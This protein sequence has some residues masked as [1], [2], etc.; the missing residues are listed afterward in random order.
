MRSDCFRSV[1][2]I[3]LDFMW[4]TKV[5]SLT[6]K[7]PEQMSSFKNI[8]VITL[9][10][11]FANAVMSQDVIF[12][13]NIT[14][15]RNKLPDRDDTLRLRPLSSLRY[16]EKDTQW[17]IRIP[18]NTD[19]SFTHVATEIEDSTLYEYDYGWLPN[20]YLIKN[21]EYKL[22]VEV[23]R[24]KETYQLETSSVEEENKYL[25]YYHWGRLPY[26]KMNQSP[27]EFKE[28]MD[29]VLQFEQEQLGTFEVNKGFMDLMSDRLK[30]DWGY[31]LFYYLMAGDE[32]ERN[33]MDTSKYLDFVK[34][35]PV[36]SIASTKT[37]YSHLDYIETFVY[38]MLKS[39]HQN[40]QTNLISLAK[41]LE[42]ILPGDVSKIYLASLFISSLLHSNESQKNELHAFLSYYENKY[43]GSEY[44]EL[45]QD[46]LTKRINEV[47][48][49]TIYDERFSLMVY[50][51]SGNPKNLQEILFSQRG[52]V[53]FLDIWASWC[54]PCIEQIPKLKNL[55]DTYRGEDLVFISL[56][57]EGK[58]YLDS[59]WKKCIQRN[60]WENWNHIL[61]GGGWESEILKIFD[62]ISVPTYVVIDRKGKVYVNMV[63]LNDYSSFKE[64]LK[65]WL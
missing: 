2:S 7:K 63:K 19:G 22:E 51:T 20:I 59:H 62:S 64:R 9:V 45:I 43:P 32:G 4:N 25:T 30:I 16:P 54:G 58:A 5:H 48:E 65:E 46:K 49:L 39:R 53:V 44:Q 17:S 36:Q 24:A 1:P 27:E 38:F 28:G 33:R 50:D 37:F 40:T 26:P 21:A 31:G 29:S 8:S 61:T 42:T 18:I 13:G 41:T 6:S 3:Y 23:M 56:S 12:R 52:K 60:S 11:L 34:S 10:L 14:I 35:V 15:D 47:F 55:R 57:V